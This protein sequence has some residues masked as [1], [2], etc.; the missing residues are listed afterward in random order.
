M[1][2]PFAISLWVRSQSSYFYFSF[3]GGFVIILSGKGNSKF[4]YEYLNIWQW[5]RQQN[6]FARCHRPHIRQNAAHRQNRSNNSTHNVDVS[7]TRY[8]PTSSARAS[9]ASLGCRFVSYLTSMP[10]VVGGNVGPKFPHS[11]SSFCLYLSLGFPQS[12]LPDPPHLPSPVSKFRIARWSS[13]VLL[14]HS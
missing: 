11:L 4:E 5:N 6:C 13:R 1:V 12:L 3:F 8:K 7:S 2:V 9:V 10:F 14:T